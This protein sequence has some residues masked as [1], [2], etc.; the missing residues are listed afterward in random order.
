M[1]SF[2]DDVLNGIIGFITGV[3]DHHPETHGLLVIRKYE[4]H[5]RPNANLHGEVSC[6]DQAYENSVFAEI[7]IENFSKKNVCKQQVYEDGVY[8]EVSIKNYIVEVQIDFFGCNAADVTKLILDAIELWELRKKYLPPNLG[9]LTHTNAVD[10]T[11]LQETTHEERF[12]VSMDF[13]YCCETS[14]DLPQFQL[15]ECMKEVIN[16]YKKNNC[17]NLTR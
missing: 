6:E 15:G 3:A 17:N 14:A 2:K 9:F 1:T 4:D 12:T 16:N 5:V 7:N 10:V 13:E 8:K 11:A